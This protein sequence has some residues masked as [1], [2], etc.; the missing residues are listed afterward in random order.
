MIKKF[1]FWFAKRYRHAPVSRWAILFI[2]LFTLVVAFAVTDLFR[3]RMS[4]LIDWPSLL[5]KLVAFMVLE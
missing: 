4:E 5:V 1:L 3:L 2:D